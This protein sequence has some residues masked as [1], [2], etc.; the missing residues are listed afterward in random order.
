M[1][2]SVAWMILGGTIHKRTHSSDAR[3]VSRVQSIWGAEQNQA[4]SRASYTVASEIDETVVENN[5]TRVVRRKHDLQVPLVV[6]SSNIDVKLDLAHRKKGLLWYSTYSVAFSGEY[7]FRNPD[8][9]A[10]HR[11]SVVFELPGERAVYDD[12]TVTVDGERRSVSVAGNIVNVDVPL[13]ASEGARV[14][15]SYKSQGLSLWRY[16]FGD[17]V[18]AVNDF[19]MKMVTNF[20]DI[21]FPD[22]TLA[23]TAKRPTGAGWELEWKY[24]NLLSGYRIA[25]AMPEK[26]Q[27]GPLAAEISFFA[28]VSLFFFFFLM[29]IITTLRG[30][31]L[32]PMNYFFL[33]A[34]FFAFHLLLAYMVDHFDIHAS[35]AIASVVSV[36]LVA[37][38]MRLVVGPRF[39][40]REV[41]AAQIVY[42]VLFS[43]AFFFR[44]FTGL[45]VTIGSIATLFVVMQATGRIRWSERFGPEPPPLATPAGT[46]SMP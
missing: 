12:L 25:M 46:A 30:I 38:Y 10:P 8:S 43:Y 6:T 22:D 4:A 18:N 17:K 40:F 31:D 5:K 29:F 13:A 15:F 14:A 39:A 7:G 3:L 42:L 36:G 45:A 28:P 34:A 2:T 44:G 11:V 33:A 27:P 32:H 1:G 19:R 16:N 9:A 20:H 21:D 37:S 35:F 26:L 23:P 24:K 41:A